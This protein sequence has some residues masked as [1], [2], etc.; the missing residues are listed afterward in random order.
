M[1]SRFRCWWLHR[2]LWTILEPGLLPFGLD[3]D[4]CCPL[5][6]KGGGRGLAS[7]WAMVRVARHV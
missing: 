4:W 5:C 3:A 7:R 2:R 6:H 1:V